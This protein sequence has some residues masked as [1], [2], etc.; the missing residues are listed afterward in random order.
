MNILIIHNNNIPTELIEEFSNN[1]NSY[2]PRV[3]D[4]QPYH[5]SDIDTFFGDSCLKIFK[6]RQYD[7]IVISYT[8]GEENYIDY[9]GL[10]I[11]THIRLTKEWNHYATPIVFLGGDDIEDVIR[12]S[13]LGGILSTYRIY[14][15]KARSQEELAKKIENINC[16]KNEI[17]FKEWLID[18][19]FQHFLNRI[20]IK[21]PA[22]YATHHSIANKWAVLRWIEMFSWEGAAPE[23]G[24]ARF[25]NM[26]YLKYLLALAGN[27]EPFTDKD[28]RKEPYSPLIENI[29]SSADYDNKREPKK[30]KRVVYIDDE[31]ALW[32]KVLAPIFEKSKVDLI[33]YPFDRHNKIER[34]ELVEKIKLFLLNDYNNNGGADCYLIDLRLHDDDFDKI[35]NMDLYT[36]KITSKDLSGHQIS[37]Y[38]KSLNKGCQVVIF[39]ASNKSWNIEKSMMKIGACGYVIKES[40]EFNYTRQESYNL[41]C[42]FAR[43]INKAFKLSYLQQ[44]YKTL[45]DFRN[46]LKDKNIDLSPLYDFADLFNLDKGQK[47][48]IIIKSCIICQMRFVESIIKKN[49]ILIEGDGGVTKNGEKIGS[50]FQRIAFSNNADDVIISNEIINKDY[51]PDGWKYAKEDADISKIVA[52]LWLYYK[53]NTEIIKYTVKLRYER[54]TSSAHG[55]QG[56]TITIT[57]L[58]NHFQKVIIPILK[59]ESEN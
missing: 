19:K 21:A 4:Y 8:L 9:S 47:S 15:S 2:F 14:T 31:E 32:S 29:Y 48:N 28:K 39:T 34:P 16:D 42:D 13:D 1:G 22:N 12:L 52:M 46:K 6:E 35:K 40:P 50:C 44:V 11:A 17:P 25:K 45:D 56:T 27:R 26:L 7:A 30:R 5:D 24:D 49:D 3:I 37:E 23:F 58:Q 41:F 36:D 33:T 20:K 55:N 18:S 53:I 38:I 51:L 10:R 54:N 57:D 43:K 59:K